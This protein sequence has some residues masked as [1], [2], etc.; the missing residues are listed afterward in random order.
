M[1]TQSNVS[2]FRRYAIF[3]IMAAAAILFSWI[4]IDYFE[5]SMTPSEWASNL[6]AGTLLSQP[7][8][9]LPFMLTAQDGNSFTLDNLRGHWTFM[10][11][12]YTSCPDIC[13]TLMMTFKTIDRKINSEGMK[14]FVDFLFISVDP[15][16]D[17]PEKLGSY[18]RYFNPR[19]RG[20]TGRSDEEIRTLT[21][22]LGL[23]YRRADGGTSETYLVD[24]SASIML[25]NPSGELNAIFSSPHDPDIISEDFATIKASYKSSIDKA[26]L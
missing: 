25:I 2:G 17:T 5:Q 15:A 24:H 12:G 9:L 19:F 7:K 13:P 26:K 23:F 6:K 3:V 22:Q 20:A 4:G 8:P 1:S 14:P 16:R 10:A 21:G 18:V 11:I